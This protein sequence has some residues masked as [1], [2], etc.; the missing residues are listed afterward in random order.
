[1]PTILYLHTNGMFPESPIIHDVVT[2]SNEDYIPN[3]VIKIDDGDFVFFVTEGDGSSSYHCMSHI[4]DNEENFRYFMDLSSQFIHARY[5]GEGNSSFAD[6][7]IKEVEDYY[8]SGYD[9]TSCIYSDDDI[10]QV[11]GFD[12][13]QHEYFF[14][15]DQEWTYEIR[16]SYKPW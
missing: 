5:D 14:D 1:M 10:K 7:A 6:S 13:H 9:S 2:F 3:T 11:L 4:D 12:I 16:F 8:Y 15:D